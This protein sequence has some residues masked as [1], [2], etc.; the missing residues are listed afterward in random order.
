MRQIGRL[1]EESLAQ[2]FANYLTATGSDAQCEAEGDQWVIWVLDDDKVDDA[3]A[4]L[5]KFEVNPNA[6]IYVKSAKLAADLEK[7]RERVRKQADKNVVRMSQ[8]WQPR[9]NGE[10]PVSLGLI[11]IS[12]LITLLTQFGGNRTNLLDSIW[13]S[14]LDARSKFEWSR[15]VEIRATQGLDE[16]RHGEVWRLV[17]PIFLHLSPLHLIFNMMWL[18]QLGRLIEWRRGSLRV[19]LFTLLIALCSN[20]L[21]YLISGPSFGGMSG[22]VYGLFGYVWIKSLLDPNSGF[23]LPPF[24]VQFMIGWLFLCFT[25]LMGPVANTA[26]LVG[27]VSG[28]VIAAVPTLLDDIRR[29]W[30]R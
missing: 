29:A 21:Q 6:E 26:H 8:R 15:R 1:T 2:R 18:Y 9:G 17:T 27:L 19:L 24:T 14:K 22:V 5:A 28:I 3:K 16:V 20:Y 23:L 13:I 30:K 12:I 7:E 4:E 25:G 11:A 10:T